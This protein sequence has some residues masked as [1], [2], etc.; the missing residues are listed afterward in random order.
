[1]AQWL[2]Y[3]HQG[4]VGFGQLQGDQIAVHAGDLFANPKATGQFLKVAELQLR[5]PAFQV[6]SL[7]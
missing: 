3:T 4:N 2:R 7:P 6:N 5:Y 1:M